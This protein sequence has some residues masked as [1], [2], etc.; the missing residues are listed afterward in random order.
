M[1]YKYKNVGMDFNKGIVLK[2]HDPNWANVFDDMKRQLEELLGNNFDFRIEHIGSTALPSIIAKPIIDI[3]LGIGTENVFRIA[4]HLAAK[5][6]SLRVTKNQD[7]VQLEDPNNRFFV[8]GLIRISNRH[9][10]GGYWQTSL[11]FKKYLLEHPV[12]LKKY[13][14]LKIRLAKK[15]TNSPPK[16]YTCEKLSFIQE[17]EDKAR[18]KYS[19]KFKE[20]F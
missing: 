12:Y 10:M 6:E 9:V 13:H 4:K 15:L 5:S 11:L 7:I 8:S 19:R 16:D 3:G 2:E 1:K 20:L 17:I 18:K 14:Y